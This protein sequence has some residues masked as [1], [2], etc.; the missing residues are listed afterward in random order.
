MC[1]CIVCL[2][3]LVFSRH[4]CSQF[5]FGGKLV[6][7]ENAKPQQQPGIEQQQQRHHVY[8]SQVVTE[9]EFLAR[10][11]QLQEAVQSEGFISYCQKKIDMAQADFEKNVWAFLKV[12]MTAVQEFPMDLE[13]QCRNGLFCALQCSGRGGVRNRK[14]RL[15]EWCSLSS[16]GRGGS[17]EE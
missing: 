17:A 1:V 8:V 14:C 2:H 16:V 10:S 13:S 9:K 12:T 6:T 3:I 7:F 5:Q 11:N 15:G 4:L